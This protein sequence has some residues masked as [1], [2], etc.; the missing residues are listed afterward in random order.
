MWEPYKKGFKA[1]LQ[2]EKSLA[3]NSVEAYLHDIDKLTDYLQAVNKMLSP[4]DLEL[5]DLEKFVQWISESG[6]TVASQS[7]I[8]S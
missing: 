2:L 6:M 7:R 3:V 4:Q 8:I 1:W 5:K